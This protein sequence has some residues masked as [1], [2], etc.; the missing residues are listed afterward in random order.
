MHDPRTSPALR[1]LA[2]LTR[3]PPRPRGTGAVAPARR[4]RPARPRPPPPHALGPGPWPMRWHHLALAR[5]RPARPGRGRSDARRAAAGSS[6]RCGCATADRDVLIGLDPTR[7]RLL[8]APVEV[9][10]RLGDVLAGD[11]MTTTALRARIVLEEARALGLDLADLIAAADGP[12][13]PCRRSPSSSPSIAPTFTAAHRR[14]L[15][16]L[17][18]P[19]RRPPRRPAPHRARPADLHA[20]VDAAAARARRNRPGL[21]PAGRLEETCVAALRALFHRAVAAG[22]VTANPAAALDQAPPGPT[23]DA[24]P[25][26]TPSWPS[27][28]T[29]CG[30]PAATPTSTCSSSA[31]TSRP[32]P[33]APAPSPSPR[34][35]RRAPRHGLAHREGRAHASSP[36]RRASSPA[37]TRHHA[38]RASAATRPLF[39]TP[40]RRP[41][42]ARDY[43]RS[44]RRARTVLPWADTHPGLG[45]RAPPHRHHRRRPHRRVPRRPG[46]RRPHP[47]DRHRPLPP[48]HPRRGRRRRRRHDRR[49]ASARAGTGSGNVRPA[50]VNE[51][52]IEHS[53]ASCGVSCSSGAGVTKSETPTPVSAAAHGRT[54]LHR[55][56]KCVDVRAPIADHRFLWHAS[57]P[58]NERS[59]VDPCRASARS[60]AHP[61]NTSIMRDQPGRRELANA[62][63]PVVR[64]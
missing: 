22:L 56:N 26:T 55:R 4:R 5:R 30:P 42:T 40:R 49:G 33:A 60:R 11:P 46:L 31:S 44:S 3:D 37:S 29:P 7:P 50:T 63:R 6:C 52:I 36:S 62:G 54:E 48:R 8:V 51:T 39:R 45:P 23:A 32:A 27:S 61:A 15:P 59:R 25:S 64:W 1:T 57:T 17:L 41:I 47:T 28:S 24:E 43:D 35:P 16:A 18:A 20:V 21:A 34:R 2:E 13:R 10:D 12:P 38:E 53:Y 58:P 9:L 14:H 19:R